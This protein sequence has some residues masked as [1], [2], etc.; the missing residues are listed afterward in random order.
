MSAVLVLLGLARFASAQLQSPVPAGLQE[1]YRDVNALNDYVFFRSEEVGLSFPRVAVTW[2]LDGLAADSFELVGQ[3]RHGRR[4]HFIAELP[5]G[6][7]R[8][9]PSSCL[10][11]LPR[12]ISCAW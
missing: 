12:A 8:C 7:T 4:R 3:E 1:Q 11:A 9:R 2:K 5:P 6:Y 10:G